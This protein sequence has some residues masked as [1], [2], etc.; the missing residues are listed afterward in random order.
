[1]AD[2][3]ACR[4]DVLLG[5]RW[6]KKESRPDARETRRKLPRAIAGIIRI[7]SFLPHPQPWPVIKS[8][9]LIPTESRPG[10]LDLWARKHPRLIKGLM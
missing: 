4:I 9:M 1:M 8:K 5:G 2:R 3:M 10:W 6:R 7:A